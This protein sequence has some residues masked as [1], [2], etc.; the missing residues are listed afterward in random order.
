MRRVN[1]EIV[2]DKETGKLTAYVLDGEAKEGVA[3]KQQEISL[4]FISK[5]KELGR[6]GERKVQGR[7]PRDGRIAAGRGLPFPDAGEA[8]E[9]AGQSDKPAGAEHFDAVIGSISVKG[10]EF[11]ES[12]FEFPEGN[13]H[14]H[15]H[16]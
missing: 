1:L 2:L 8:S 10:Q 16:H 3:I 11:K 15:H 9:F 7:A 5:R 13:E 6:R 14:D 4:A 12:K